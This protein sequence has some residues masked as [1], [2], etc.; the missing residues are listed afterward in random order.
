MTLIAGGRVP[1]GGTHAHLVPRGGWVI[2][3]ETDGTLGT[4][5][6]IFCMMRVGGLS[7]RGTNCLLWVLTVYFEI[8]FV[9][10]F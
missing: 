4:N 3:V 10:F 7:N 2:L 6:S 8:V 9:L 1:N 5:W